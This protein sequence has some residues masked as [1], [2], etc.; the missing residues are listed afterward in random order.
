MVFDNVLSMVNPPTV[1]KR[2]WFV[3]WF[4]G[5]AL[6]TLWDQNSILGVSTFSMQDDVDEGFSISVAGGGSA[7]RGTIIA[8]NAERHFDPVNCIVES[9][10]RKLCNGSSK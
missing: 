3:E 10:Q 5:N 4:Y 2:S 6:K 8:A 1:L 7:N 9:I